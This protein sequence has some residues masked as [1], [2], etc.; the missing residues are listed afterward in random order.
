MFFS[1]Q[2][3]E[4]DPA[5]NIPFYC[6]IGF[7]HCHLYGLGNAKK[8]KECTGQVDICT[9]SQSCKNVPCDVQQ[10]FL[11]RFQEKL[12]YIAVYLSICLSG[13]SV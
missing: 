2:K 1:G 13:D 4:S 12:Q 10:K 9:D 8:S 5:D 7:P 6:A 11:Q 3:K